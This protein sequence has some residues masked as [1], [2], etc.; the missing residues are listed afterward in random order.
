MYLRPHVK[1]P[2][3]LSD[4]NERWNFLDISSKYTQISNF[5]NIR[6][7]GDEMFSCGRTNRQNEANNRLKTEACPCVTHVTPP[8]TIYNCSNIK[9]LWYRSIVTTFEL[10]CPQRTS[11]EVNLITR[12]HASCKFYF[13]KFSKVY[14]V[15]F[16]PTNSGPEPILAHTVHMRVARELKRSGLLV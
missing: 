13:L 9:T 11:S 16:S 14:F 8:G 15:S 12:R 3:F 2:L 5:M 7:V 4:F 10:C 6:P 1:H